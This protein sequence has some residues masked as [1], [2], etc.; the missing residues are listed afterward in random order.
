MPHMVSKMEKRVYGEQIILD[1]A[2]LNTK[3]L[4]N[5]ARQYI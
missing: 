5:V 1:N 3:T 4:T 2:F